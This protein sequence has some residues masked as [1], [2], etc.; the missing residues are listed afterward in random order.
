MVYARIYF[1]FVWG[2]HN[3]R[4]LVSV[5]CIRVYV[6]KTRDIELISMKMK[7]LVLR[8]I[9]P[10]LIEYIVLFQRA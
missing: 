7:F 6:H 8:N 3:A 2:T 1:I 5:V 9:Y 4:I 10:V